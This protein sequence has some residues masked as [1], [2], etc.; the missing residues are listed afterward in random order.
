MIT[1]ILGSTVLQGAV[2]YLLSDKAGSW[3][4]N[5]LSKKGLLGLGTKASKAV[6]TNRLERRRTQARD[7]RVA[8]LQSEIDRLNG[9]ATDA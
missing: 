9:D 7:E 1:A 2:V 6:A 8:F 3:A 5:L 4:S